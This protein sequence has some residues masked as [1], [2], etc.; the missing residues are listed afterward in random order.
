MMYQLDEVQFENDII[1]LLK[2]NVIKNVVG[3]YPNGTVNF[4]LIV[5]SLT[6]SPSQYDI[7]KNIIRSRV[8]LTVSVWDATKTSLVKTKQKIE[9]TLLRYGF[10]RLNPSNIIIDNTNEKYYFNEQFVINYDNMSNK[11]E[12]SI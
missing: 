8:S 1:S 6:T 2:N 7:S 11:F 9:Q 10:T 3:S 5:T 12:R 4:P